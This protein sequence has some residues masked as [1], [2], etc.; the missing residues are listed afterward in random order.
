MTRYFVPGI[1]VSAVLG[2]ALLWPRDGDA[3][4]G[5]PDFT[6]VYTGDVVGKVEPCG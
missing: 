6:I 3:T 5:K 2:I 4:L 1:L